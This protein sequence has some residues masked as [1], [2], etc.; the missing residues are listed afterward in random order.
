M[1]HKRCISSASCS[2]TWVWKHPFYQRWSQEAGMSSS[3]ILCSDWLWPV[4]LAKILVSSP[5]SHRC[6]FP[7]T[8]P[9]C[10]RKWR[11]SAWACGAGC[12]SYFRGERCCS[13]SRRRCRCRWTPPCW[14]GRVQGRLGRRGK[15]HLLALLQ[16]LRRTSAR[17]CGC[18]R[19]YWRGCYCWSGWSTESHPAEDKRATFRQARRREV[20]KRDG[21]MTSLTFEC[22]FGESFPGTSCLGILL[23]PPPPPGPRDTGTCQRGSRQ[24][25]HIDT[26]RIKANYTEPPW[27]AKRIK[28]L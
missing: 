17:H 28:Y 16:V 21:V 3:G 5:P 12:W 14:E 7:R 13:G 11:S 24:K 20:N 26:R 25:T 18:W 6:S 4:W 27:L 9:G 10:R 22:L 1:C 2:L 23:W 19:R 15:P 8:A